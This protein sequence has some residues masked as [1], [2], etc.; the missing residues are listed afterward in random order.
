M[1]PPVRHRRRRRRT[2]RVLGAAAGGLLGAAFLPAAAAFADDWD[3]VADPSQYEAPTGIYG[4]GFGGAD[5]APPAVEGSIQGHQVFDYTDT[6]TDDTGTFE[7]LESSS[8]D[9]FGDTN[10]EVSVTSD[11]SGAGAPSVG[12]VFDT[13]TFDDGLAENVYSDIYSPSGDT[14]TDTLETPLGNYSI[15]VTFDAADVTVADAGG[16]VIGN[17]DEIDPVGSQAIN[18]IS[19]IPPLTVGDQGTQQFDVD[20]SNGTPVGSFDA[21]DTTTADG[22]GTYTEAVLVTPEI[23]GTDVSGTAGTADGD[24]PA[25]GS[26]FNTIDFGDIENV[27]SDLVGSNGAN[28]I[29]DTLD[30]PFGDS[31][32]PT[33]FDAA[34]AETTSAIDLPGGEDLDPTTSLHYTGING[35]APADVGVQGTQSFDVDGNATDTFTADVTNTLDI[36]DD[37]TESLMVTSSS[38][39]D[40]PVGSVFE[41]VTWGDTGFENIYSDIASASGAD[42]VT[43]TVVTPFGDFTIPSA[44]DAAAGLATD[45]LSGM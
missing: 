11:V 24:V 45:L 20:D 13:Y 12:S 3:V 7:G 41:T 44:L 16:V 17:E 23:S 1:E 4:Y 22:A 28:V 14:I 34:Q 15:P 35:L 38:D 6:T 43:D 42:V 37:S 29:T 33:T 18:A 31:E 21:D 10:V 36:F 8:T 32:I 2:P 19:G 27:Y 5:T 9:G 39:P 30:T 26:I 40:I 25:V